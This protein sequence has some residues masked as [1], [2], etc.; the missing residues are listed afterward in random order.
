L[1]T[2]K[3]IHGLLECQDKFYVNLNFLK[4]VY[5][6]SIKI[7][8]YYWVSGVAGNRCTHAEVIC[9]NNLETSII[10]NAPFLSYSLKEFW[11]LERA[12]MLSFGRIQLKL[13][14]KKRIVHKETI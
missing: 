14:R 4:N 6:D 7:L 13:I 10:L 11:I 9:K 1:L 2:K 12:R 3:A 8:R 5:E